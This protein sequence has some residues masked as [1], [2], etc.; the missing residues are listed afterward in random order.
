[1]DIN[2]QHKFRFVADYR[3]LNEKTTWNAHPLVDITEILDLLGQGKY[4]PCLDLAMGY[5]Q[6]DIRLHETDII[7]FSIKHRHWV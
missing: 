5:H 1:M 4:F 2:W 7:A 6:I 3:K